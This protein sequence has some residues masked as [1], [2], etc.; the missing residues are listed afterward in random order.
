MALFVFVIW[1][2]LSCLWRDC[3]AYRP[4]IVMHGVFA[5]NADMSGF[6]DMIK[7]AHPGTEVKIAP[8]NITML[9]ITTNYFIILLFNSL[10]T[11]T[12]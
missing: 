5:S 1:L 7:K 9:Y 10:K 11:N 3:L 4:V 2:S 8:Y 6:V 12:M